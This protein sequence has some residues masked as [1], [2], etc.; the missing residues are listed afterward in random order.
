MHIMHTT[1]SLVIQGKND[2]IYQQNSKFA[3]H[4]PE[5]NTM[6]VIFVPNNAKM[7]TFTA[8]IKHKRGDMQIKCIS[9]LIFQFGSF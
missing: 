9:P 1:I 8:D 2:K 5:I 7:L 3:S 6:S 4:F